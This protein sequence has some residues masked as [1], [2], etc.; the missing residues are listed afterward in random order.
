M[1]E[2]EFKDILGK[3]IKLFRTRSNYSQTAFARKLGMTTNFIGDMEN[4]KK[5]PS[6]VTIVRMA[7]L[8]EIEPYHFLL[9]TDEIS[10]DTCLMYT[11]YNDEFTKTIHETMDNMYRKYIKKGKSK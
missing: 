1:K 9:N 7:N 4:G 2:S 3:N 5:Y 10:K 6:L 11:K 8:L